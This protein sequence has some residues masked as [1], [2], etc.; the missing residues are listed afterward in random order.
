MPALHVHKASVVG[1]FMHT[2]AVAAPTREDGDAEL[3]DQTLARFAQ[4]NTLT[5]PLGHLKRTRSVK[6]L[7]RAS[8][9]CHAPVS[10]TRR[11]SR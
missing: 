1:V 2:I 5:G 8:L 6:G 10:Y 7:A 3:Y 11:A 4:W 9:M